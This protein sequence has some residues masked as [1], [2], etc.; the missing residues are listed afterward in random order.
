MRS[1]VV[2]F[3]LAACVLPLL[4]LPCVPLIGIAVDVYKS[5]QERHRLLYETDHQ[6]LLAASRE[7]MHDHVGQ[8]IADPTQDPRV[9]LIIRELGPSYIDVSAEQVRVELHGGFD[10]YG[11][12]ALA[13]DV[14]SRDG[15]SKLID[16]LFYYTE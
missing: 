10:H 11:Y 4:A 6:A 12:I 16:G 2:F 9:P 8:H 5:N 1:K 15:W 14:N 3:V 13:D 7:L